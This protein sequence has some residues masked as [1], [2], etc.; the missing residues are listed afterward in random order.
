M[1]VEAGGLGGLYFSLLSLGTIELKI[2]HLPP[3]K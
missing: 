3:R 1:Y 2:E